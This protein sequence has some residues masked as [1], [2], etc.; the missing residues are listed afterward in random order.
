[1]AA[2]VGEGCGRQLLFYSAACCITLVSALSFQAFHWRC[3]ESPWWESGA[4]PM[5]WIDLTL[6]LWWRLRA[7]TASVGHKAIKWVSQSGTFLKWKANLR[8]GLRHSL[9]WLNKIIPERDRRLKGMIKII[10]NKAQWV[11]NTVCVSDLAKVS[12]K[13]NESIMRKSWKDHISWVKFKELHSCTSI[14]DFEIKKT[15]KK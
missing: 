5:Q 6:V 11:W 3:D 14:S 12:L 8:T 9:I 1:M 2:V 7:Y 4:F 10:G 13:M 15:S